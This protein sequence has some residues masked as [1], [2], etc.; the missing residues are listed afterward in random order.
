MIAVPPGTPSPPCPREVQLAIAGP[1]QSPLPV[2]GGV[3]VSVE[4]TV[5]PDGSVQNARIAQSS[6]NRN[7]DSAA[8]RV[9]RQST[10]LPKLVLVRRQSEDG[11]TGTAGV[12]DTCKAVVGTY[13]FKVT[14]V[15]NS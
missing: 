10:Y 12:G 6:G 3:N 1:A 7:L 2:D 8:I 13:Q 9:A 15:P 11:A 5:A 14:F 4:V